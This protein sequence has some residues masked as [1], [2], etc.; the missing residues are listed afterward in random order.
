[1][2]NY[3]NYH[4]HNPN[5]TPADSS[6]YWRQTFERSNNKIKE[7]RDS[8]NTIYRYLSSYLKSTPQDN[9]LLHNATDQL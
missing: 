3:L 8:A 1:M 2:D 7:R 9:S 5:Y 6:D 4:K